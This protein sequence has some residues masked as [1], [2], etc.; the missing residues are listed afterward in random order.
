MQNKTK[1]A[2]ITIKYMREISSAAKSTPNFV[3][4]M[5]KTRI[6]KCKITNEGADHDTAPL[7]QI[8]HRHKPT[9]PTSHAVSTRC[10][11]QACF[12]ENDHGAAICQ[13][14]NSRA[15]SALALS[16][17]LAACHVTDATILAKPYGTFE[18]A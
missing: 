7:A 9:D 6:P 17:G 1:F 2:Q 13:Q 14:T 8:H 12:A 5:I 3:T 4:M 15:L 18:K 10:A 16:T 11:P